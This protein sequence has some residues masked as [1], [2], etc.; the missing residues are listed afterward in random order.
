MKIDNGELNAL[1][2]DLGD[3]GALAGP[4]I[5]S[6]IQYTSKEIQTDARKSVGK[7]KHF[8]QAAAAI[9]YEVS[10]FQGF[11]ASVIKAEIGYDKSVASG[12]LGNLIE[13]GAPNSTSGPLTPTSD[14]ANAMKANEDDFEKGLAKALADAEKKAGL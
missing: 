2:A 6:A 1:A 13:F 12:A 4:F 3:V 9:D 8:G 7:R 11:G 10:V 14:L 5:N